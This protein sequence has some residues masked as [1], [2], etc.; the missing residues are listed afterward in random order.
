MA[1]WITVPIR[2]VSTGGRTYILPTDRQIGLM[3]LQVAR[4]V[5]ARDE[6][7]T[8]ED[9]KA[10]TVQI[11]LAQQRVVNAR[12]AIKDAEKMDGYFV[13]NFEVREPEFGSVVLSEE[14]AANYHDGVRL[15]DTTKL[16]LTLLT[17]NV[18]KAGGDPMTEDEV[19]QLRPMIASHLHDEIN[20]LTY[21]DW[22]RLPFLKASST[23][24]SF[25]V[26]PE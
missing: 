22:S 21:P 24:S 25:E 5:A 8:P 26:A 6:A 7:Q 10:A 4:I 14:K 17:G 15:L 23:T 18:R 20:D 2:Q 19:K 16:M 11:N 13:D 9:E 3:E 12:K 1:T